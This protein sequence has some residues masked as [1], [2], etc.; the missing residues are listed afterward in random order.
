[1][2]RPAQN[3]MHPETLFREQK[4]SQDKDRLSYNML[5]YNHHH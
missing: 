2:Y 3:M 4:M 1:M 5:H